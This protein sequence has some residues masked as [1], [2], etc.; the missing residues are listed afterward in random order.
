MSHWRHYEHQAD[1]GIEG[2]GPRLED[3]FTQAA[4]A[5]TA[6]ITEPETISPDKEI[7]IDCEAPNNEIL[8]VDWLNALVYEMA[9]Q[10]MLFNRFEVEISSPDTQSVTLKARAWGEKIIPEKHQPVVEIKGATFTTLRVFEDDQQL[11]HAQ[12]VVD[13]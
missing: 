2:I 6:V 8:F 12:T 1:I 5:L 13:V 9:S 4:L 3:A 11:W 7:V 10:K